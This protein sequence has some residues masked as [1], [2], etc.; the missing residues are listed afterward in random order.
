[1]WFALPSLFNAISSNKKNGLPQLDSKKKSP[2]T[3]DEFASNYCKLISMIIVDPRSRTLQL[4]TKKQIEN[5]YCWPIITDREQIYSYSFVTAKI[6]LKIVDMKLF[7]RQSLE[8]LMQA[9]AKI[10]TFWM[11]TGFE[12]KVLKLPSNAIPVRNRFTSTFDA[13]SVLVSWEHEYEG[14]ATWGR[15]G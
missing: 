6:S 12:N 5:C 13:N 7:V 2:I 10:E 14:E 11:I 15:T 9:K 1:M 3:D 4:K 8:C